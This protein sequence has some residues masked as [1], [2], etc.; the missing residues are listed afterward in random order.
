[1]MQL[2]IIDRLVK[3]VLLRMRPRALV[4]LTAADG[5]KE[6][7]QARLRQG[8][9]L[10]STFLFADNARE[11][12]AENE[13]CQIGPIT[14][15]LEITQVGALDNIDR[16]LIPFLDF[17]TAAELA[18][19]LLQSDSAQLIHLARLSGKPIMALDY[20]CNPASELNQLKGLSRGAVLSDSLPKLAARGIQLCTL[21]QMLS[22]E[23]AASKA[24]AVGYITLSELKRR[25]GLAPPGARLTDLALEYSRGR[26]NQKY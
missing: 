23:P 2:E 4:L 22:A 26:N 8:K 3:E 19:G 16:V 14:T 17:S 9:T 12:H 7:I 18:N 25:N 20:N 15:L 10:S 1:M 6:I 24:P 13:W 11:F 21:D 5:Y